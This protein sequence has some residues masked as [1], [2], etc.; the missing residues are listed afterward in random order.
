MRGDDGERAGLGG[1][2]AAEGGEDVRGHLERGRRARLARAHR[3]AR[4]RW[5]RA[6]VRARVRV[7]VKG[8]GFR[9]N[10]REMYGGL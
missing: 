10:M 6:K 2:E 5:V 1:A 3:P 4:Y 9:V 7:R 8:L